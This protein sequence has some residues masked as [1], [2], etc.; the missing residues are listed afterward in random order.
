MERYLSTIDPSGQSI[1]QPQ[2][3]LFQG[4]SQSQKRRPRQSGKS[5]EKR[6]ECQQGR[7]DLVW[8][9]MRLLRIGYLDTALALL[10][11]SKTSII[12]LWRRNL[13]TDKKE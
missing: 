8:S 5:L 6:E 1:C 9:M 7:R 12:G 13:S 11:R 2:P 4:R 3:S 10:R